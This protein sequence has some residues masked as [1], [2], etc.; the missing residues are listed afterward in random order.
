MKVKISSIWKAVPNIKSQ[1]C[2]AE[3]PRKLNLIFTGN[4]HGG[5]QNDKI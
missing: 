5:G 4:F 1:C 3:W 2:G